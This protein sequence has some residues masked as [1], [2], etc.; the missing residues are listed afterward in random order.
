MNFIETGR[1]NPNGY[2]TSGRK[3]P[4]ASGGLGGLFRDAFTLGYA[5]DAF[6]AGYVED[7]FD[8]G[9]VEDAFDAGKATVY[10]EYTSCTSSSD[11]GSGYSCI[12]G[13]CMAPGITGA[14]S[15]SGTTSGSS[16]VS[17]EPDPNPIP[18]PGGPGGSSCG[19]STPSGSS[20][21]PS[22]G[23][24][25]KPGCSKD[26]SAINGAG[27]GGYADECCG[28]RCC[29]FFSSG[30]GGV[31]VQCFCGPCPPPQRC[32]E[33]CDSYDKA[34]GS[35]PEG[36]NAA[37]YCSECEY[38]DSFGPFTE[39]KPYLSGG[40]CWCGGGNACSNSCE[41]CK[42]DGTCEYDCN[43]CETCLTM[44]NQ[45][46]NCKEGGPKYTTIRC[47][48]SSCNQSD[49]QFEDCKNDGCDSVC[50]PGGGGG[51][52]CKGDCY[53]RT[54]CEQAPPP[55]CDFPPCVQPSS[56]PPCPA[57]SSCKN[58]GFISAG[59]E[60]CYVEEVCDKGNVPSSCGDSE[61]NC[62]LDCPD[63]QLCGTDGKCY[64]DPRCD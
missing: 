26:V 19:G 55:D 30:P 50:P 1:G 33:Y 56:C 25:S 20:F 58:I 22:A 40:P 38:C 51:D 42:V 4:K 57:G 52:P 12:D 35:P 60:T 29:R 24:C 63:C 32:Q 10:A 61:C 53:N 28:E 5:K 59:G 15:G 16:S 13:R 64:P 3:A 21:T 43:N 8:A 34:F 6:A 45:L 41:Q 46:C 62:H 54:C 17:C 44:Y 47:C 48:T 18:P 27:G 11:C 23:P 31:G 14:G 37:T 49:L 9:Y 36:C 2:A 7:A 39:C